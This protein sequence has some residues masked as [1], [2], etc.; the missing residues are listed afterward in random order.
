MAASSDFRYM[1]DK[2][3]SGTVVHTLARLEVGCGHE[4]FKGSGVVE[5]SHLEKVPDV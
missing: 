5:N 4:A 2:Q 3:E 1:T